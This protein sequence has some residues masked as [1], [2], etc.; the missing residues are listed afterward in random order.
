MKALAGGSDVVL[1]LV[2]AGLSSSKGDDLDEA[3]SLLVEAGSNDPPVWCVD[4]VAAARLVGAEIERRR[5]KRAPRL[6]PHESERQRP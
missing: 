6:Y 4:A 3:L 2:S 5:R 1:S